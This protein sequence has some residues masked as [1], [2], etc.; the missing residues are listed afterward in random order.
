MRRIAFKGVIIKKE[1]GAK[2]A[3][4]EVTAA[5]WCSIQPSYRRLAPFTE[6]TSITPMSDGTPTGHQNFRLR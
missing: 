2:D 4:L 6:K 1:G 5:L 3:C